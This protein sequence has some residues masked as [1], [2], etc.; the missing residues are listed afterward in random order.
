M[1][2][3]ARVY[4]QSQSG[5]YKLSC[6]VSLFLQHLTI[7]FVYNIAVVMGEG[8]EGDSTSFSTQTPPETPP[9]SLFF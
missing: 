2:I 4:I 8:L 5:F 7:T 9:L 6:E 1:M 3:V